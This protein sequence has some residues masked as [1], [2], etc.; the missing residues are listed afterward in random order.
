MIE[1]DVTE[2]YGDYLHPSPLLVISIKCYDGD[3]SL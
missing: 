1:V 2:H 3:E